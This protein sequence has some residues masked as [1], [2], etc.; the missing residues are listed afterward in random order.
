[1]TDLSSYKINKY[2][3]FL[4]KSLPSRPTAIRDLYA[5]PGVLD[6]AFNGS[7]KQKE[8][9]LQKIANHMGNYLGLLNPVKIHFVEKQKGGT[10]TETIFYGGT[11]GKISKKT[12]TE[13]TKYAGLYKVLGPL[14]KEIIIVNDSSFYLIHFLSV[15]AHEVTHNYLF[16][17]KI[18]APANLDNEILT[19]LAAVYLGFGLTLIRGY[20][21]SEA[22]RC[23]LGYINPI[24]IRKA[25]IISY[26]HRNWYYKEIVTKFGWFESSKYIFGLGLLS[27]ALLKTYK[28]KNKTVTTNQI[29][30][31]IITCN[32]CAKKIRVPM[33]KKLFK[34]FCP[35]CSAEFHVKEG[36]VVEN[37]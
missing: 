6:Y 2:I 18:N 35:A 16:H 36:G 31:T 17:H 12:Y 3:S 19:D 1:M 37:H 29:H 22:T 25:L 26:S 15:L 14:H 27:A 9:A 33:S 4:N 30:K 10:K 5:L 8:E 7:T 13:E 28:R 24:T 34:V 23:L 11:N 32:N 21:P 20:E